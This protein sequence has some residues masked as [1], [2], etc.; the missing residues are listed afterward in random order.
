MSE[1]R[2]F[3]GLIT[4]GLPGELADDN[5]KNRKET[6]ECQTKKNSRDKHSDYSIDYRFDYVLDYVIIIV[7]E[8]IKTFKL[9]VIV[10]LITKTAR[11]HSTHCK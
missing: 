2:N 10:I 4:E 7:I 5:E 11:L 8:Q 6:S 9:I 1:N 3:R